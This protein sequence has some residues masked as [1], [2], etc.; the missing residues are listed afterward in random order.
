MVK[1][2]AVMRINSNSTRVPLNVAKLRVQ[3]GRKRLQ[4]E[5]P[6]NLL[7]K[8]EN[9]QDVDA[10]VDAPVSE[11]LLE[12]AAIM[13]S[14][15]EQMKG[16]LTSTRLLLSPSIQDA[17]PPNEQLIALIAT[18]GVCMMGWNL[19]RRDEVCSRSHCTYV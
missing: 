6:R 8:Y 4:V 5:F 17:P 14:E 10:C 13:G 2:A 9:A 3:T 1:E 12:P 15:V 18:V 16:P 7:F 19:Q 11:S